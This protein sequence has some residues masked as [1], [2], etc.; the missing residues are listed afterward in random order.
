MHS[1]AGIKVDI[2]KEKAWIEYRAKSV[3]SDAPVNIPMNPIDAMDSASGIGK[4]IRPDRAA[5]WPPAHRR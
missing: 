5:T 3:T 4:V 2:D 1:E